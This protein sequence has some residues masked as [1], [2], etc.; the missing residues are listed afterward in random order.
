MKKLILVALVI[1][2]AGC[3]GL[4]KTANSFTTRNVRIADEN[5]KLVE[6]S[7]FPSVEEGIKNL[8]NTVIYQLIDA[9]EF[10]EFTKSPKRLPYAY[11]VGV[12]TDAMRKAESERKSSNES[13]T[14]E[15]KKVSYPI[16]KP[17]VWHIDVSISGAN[18]EP[19]YGNRF[20]PYSGYI[21][22]SFSLTWN[23]SNEPIDVG[24]QYADSSTITAHRLTGGSGSTGFNVDASK[25]FYAWVI[26]PAD[27][28]ANISSYQGTISLWAQ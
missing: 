5:L 2:I 28:N 18:L 13:L 11:V 26:N 25:P 27:N 19:G 20:G 8:S 23:P 22:V 9:K 15:F 12:D 6:V 24:I 1:I 16:A 14:V 21:Y 4:V 10:E 3:L 7:E 17:D